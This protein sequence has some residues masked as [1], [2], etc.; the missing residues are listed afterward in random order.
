MI[1]IYNNNNNNFTRVAFEIMAYE[2]LTV[3][4]GAS[5]LKHH[6]NCTSNLNLGKKCRKNLINT[7]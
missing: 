4:G 5:P 7:F 6:F 1:R 2:R 3:E